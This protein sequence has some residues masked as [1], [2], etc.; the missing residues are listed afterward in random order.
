MT[1]LLIHGVPD[2]DRLWG[3]VLDAL[4]AEAAGVQALSLPG[5]GCSAPDGF[6]HTMDAYAGW[7]T[8]ELV[9]AADRSGGPVDLVGHDWGGLL[10]QRVACLR[11]ELVRSWAA[12]GVAIDEDYV[13]HDVAQIWQTPGAGEELMAAM[14]DALF[15][16][17]LEE[18]RV[19]REHAEQMVSHGDEV[20]RA[21]ILALYRSAV[22]IGADWSGALDR[23]PARG[24]VIWGE[25][26]PYAAPDV[27]RRL[28]ARCG[29][30]FHLFEACGHWW[31]Y[32]RPGETA[33]LL[34]ALWT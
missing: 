1:R 14:D 25:H 8:Q 30:R 4:G 18:A 9:A 17:T 26:D 21:A 6:S 11:P 34:K 3:P 29:A 15:I 19:P 31:P 10:V 20:M 5:F 27:G 24:L 23:L 28:A 33:A 7:L 13:W 22:N 2:T 32:E 16:A 12:G